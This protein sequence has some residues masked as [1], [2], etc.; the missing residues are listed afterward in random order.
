MLSIYPREAKY[1]T[2]EIIPCVNSLA[3]NINGSKSKTEG[4]EVQTQLSFLSN[5]GIEELKKLT[6]DLEHAVYVVNNIQEQIKKA[7]LLE[8]QKRDVKKKGDKKK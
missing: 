2:I 1:L 3:R 4:R 8:K 7:F 5:Y 6:D